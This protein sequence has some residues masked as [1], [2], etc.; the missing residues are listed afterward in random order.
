MKLTD[1]VAPRSFAVA[2]CYTCNANF[3]AIVAI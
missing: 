2:F 3:Y 1:K